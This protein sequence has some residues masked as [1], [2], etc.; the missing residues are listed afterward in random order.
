MND[1]II[2]APA[3]SYIST[4]DNNILLKTII[5]YDQKELT[6]TIKHFPEKDQTWLKDI[7]P[8]LLQQA[9]TQGFNEAKHMVRK[10]LHEALGT[11]Q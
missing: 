4:Q 7:I 6:L 2:P 1:P 3:Q 11:K 5:G 9:Y 8:R 10:R